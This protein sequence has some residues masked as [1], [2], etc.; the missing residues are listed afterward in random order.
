MSQFNQSNLQFSP[1]PDVAVV[2]NHLLDI[3]ERRDGAPKQAVRVNL[4]QLAADLP[5]YFSQL[6]P[7]PRLTAN[8]QLT[9]L[10]KSG[11]LVAPNC[12]NCHGAHDIKAEDNPESKVNWHN[13]PNT[14]GACHVDG[15]SGLL[16]SFYFSFPL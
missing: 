5:G 10:E 16:L 1:S 8:E 11:L 2:M 13:I 3:Y 9:T 12:S 6:D 7:L 15:F 14:C 4:E